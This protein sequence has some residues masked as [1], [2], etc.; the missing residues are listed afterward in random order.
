MRVELLLCLW[1][2]LRR[3]PSYG[4]IT[5][6]M[7]RFEKLLVMQILSDKNHMRRQNET[8]RKQEMRQFPLMSDRS[9]VE[10]VEPTKSMQDRRL[11]MHVDAHTYT[12]VHAP[13]ERLQ[14]DHTVRRCEVAKRYSY[15][16][17]LRSGKLGEH[18]DNC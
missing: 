10:T 12:D 9:C 4:I 15:S 7:T 5:D 6:R 2:F 14:T 18:G 1:V 11:E 8:G 16:L 3:F 17:K 13:R